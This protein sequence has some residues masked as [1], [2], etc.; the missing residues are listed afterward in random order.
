MCFL[1]MNLA[2]VHLWLSVALGLACLLPG[3]EIHSA[4]WP[5][6]ISNILSYSPSCVSKHPVNS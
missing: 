1:Q 2:P 3:G 4:Q 6:F 5:S